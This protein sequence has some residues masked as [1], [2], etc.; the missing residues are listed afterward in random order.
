MSGTCFY[1]LSEYQRQSSN[2]A[3]Q[4]AIQLPKIQHVLLGWKKQQNKTTTITTEFQSLYKYIFVSSV[5]DQNHSYCGTWPMEWISLQWRHYGRDG[6]WNHQPH[7]CLLNRLLR[8]GSKKTSKAR[9]T[10]LCAGNSPVTGEFPTQMPV[11]RK[12]FLFDDVII[13]CPHQML[14]WNIPGCF[15]YHL[16]YFGIT[17]YVL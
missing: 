15:L 5:C 14:S 17:L 16:Q 13:C 9:V 12:M 11:T 2:L 7:D 10:D 4:Q 8:R 1:Y 6:V 3:M